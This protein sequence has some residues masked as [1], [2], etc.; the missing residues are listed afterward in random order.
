MILKC[1]PFDDNIKNS[2]LFHNEIN[3]NNLINLLPHV[4][5]W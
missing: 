1:L 2:F 4:L 3:V 5:A